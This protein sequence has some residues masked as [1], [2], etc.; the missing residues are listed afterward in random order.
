[1]PSFHL[2]FPTSLTDVGK[3]WLQSVHNTLTVLLLCGHSWQLFQH[4]IPPM[5]C[6]PSWTNPTE[7]SHRQQLFKSCS[8]M[9]PHHRVHP[10]GANCSGMTPPSTATPP[11]FP[12][13]VWALLHWLQLWPGACSYRG[14]PWAA[15]SSRPHPPAT[16]GAPPQAAA[17]R[18]ASCET[19]GLQGDFCFNI[20]S[21]SCPPWWLQGCF[22][23]VS[24]FSL[25]AAVAQCHFPFLNL[26][27][28][29]RKQQCSQAQL[30]LVVGSLLELAVAGSDL[31]WGSFWTLLTEAT[32]AASCYQNLT[33]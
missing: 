2:P 27:S 7:A 10:S 31:T 24:D 14:S 16:L 12:A 3:W 4:E 9:G 8:H 5:G 17:W 11:R 23:T 15:T 29:R 20:C 19:H 1:M 13:C 22:S 30:W 21:T 25:L 28:Q 6:C 33:T 18:S 26:L 32:C